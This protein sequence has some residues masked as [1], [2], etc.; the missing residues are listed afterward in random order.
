MRDVF[1]SSLL[2]VAEGGGRALGQ[3]AQRHVAGHRVPRV[4]R[5]VPVHAPQDGLDPADV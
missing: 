1:L 3:L 4:G 5:A 2:R